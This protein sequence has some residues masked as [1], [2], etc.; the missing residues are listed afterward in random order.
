MVNPTARQLTGYSLLRLAVMCLHG[1]RSFLHRS[2]EGEIDS[3][4]VFSCLLS[5]NIDYGYAFFEDF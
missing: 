1:T 2:F 3:P 5:L 4:V